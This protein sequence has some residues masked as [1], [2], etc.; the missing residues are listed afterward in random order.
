M[1]AAG[2]QPHPPHARRP[3]PAHVSL[4][5]D[6][7]VFIW[8]PLRST[9]LTTSN[10]VEFIFQSK[11]VHIVCTVCMFACLNF[12]TADPSNNW[13]GALIYFFKGPLHQKKHR[14]MLQIPA[15]IIYP[16][17]NVGVTNV[18]TSER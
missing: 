2:S 10:T 6:I 3:S 4:Q 8:S 5:R 12:N 17:K 1:L 13:I 7:R 11:K 9:L 14:H 18:A 15:N 16:H